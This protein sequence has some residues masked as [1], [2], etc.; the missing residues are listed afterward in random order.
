MGDYN[1]LS[2]DKHSIVQLLKTMVY[3][4]LITRFSETIQYSL[5]ES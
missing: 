2:Y 1:L 4:K 5:K 3:I